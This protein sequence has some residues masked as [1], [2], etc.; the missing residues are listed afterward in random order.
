MT[1]PLALLTPAHH[2]TPLGW[3]SCHPPISIALKVASTR[4]ESRSL[5]YQQALM[6]PSVNLQHFSSTLPAALET[7]VLTA[8]P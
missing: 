3:T 2:Q 1:Q 6:E 5:I 4:W 7:L 8:S